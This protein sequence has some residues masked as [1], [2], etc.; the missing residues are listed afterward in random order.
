MVA[1]Y[2]RRVTATVQ[3]KA[4]SF[5]VACVATGGANGA[6]CNSNTTLDTIVPN[7]VKELQNESISIMSLGVNDLGPDGAVGGLCPPTCGTGDETRY[8]EQGVFTP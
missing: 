8:L 4:F 2:R 7:F 3:D 6:Q 5:L 1:G